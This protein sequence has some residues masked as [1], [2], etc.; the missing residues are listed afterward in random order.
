M[1]LS[2][3]RVTWSGSSEPRHNLDAAAPADPLAPDEAAEEDDDEPCAYL[4]HQHDIHNFAFVS[5][6]EFGSTAFF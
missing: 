5:H 4:L 6:R 3:Q 1:L 2:N